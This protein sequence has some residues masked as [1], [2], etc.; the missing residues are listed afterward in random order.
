MLVVVAAVVVVDRVVDLAGLLLA[1]DA[2]L[3][4]SFGSGLREAAVDR[5]ADVLDKTLSSLF[6]LKTVRRVPLG[7][8]ALRAVVVD[9]AAPDLADETLSSSFELKTARRAT[10]GL[11]GLREVVVVVFNQDPAE[12]KD[13]TLSAS[14]FALL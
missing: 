4:S 2:T 10:L 11:S 9:R 8:S 14:S 3:S 7:L 5:A 12:T 1:D 13:E 6:E